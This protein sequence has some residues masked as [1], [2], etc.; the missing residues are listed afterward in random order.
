MTHAEMVAAAASGRGGRWAHD[1]TITVHDA[2]RDVASVTLNS[3]GF[4]DY[5][6]IARFED[7]WRIVNV[8]WKP[9]DRWSDRLLSSAMIG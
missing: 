9:L 4:V 8:L 2:F 7:R 3:A 1:Y 6:H 5:L